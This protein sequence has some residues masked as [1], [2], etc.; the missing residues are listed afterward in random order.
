MWERILEAGLP[1]KGALER[2]FLF[3]M[4]S[5]VR[6]AAEVWFAAMYKCTLARVLVLHKMP[7]TICTVALIDNKIFPTFFQAHVPHQS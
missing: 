5:T 7:S 3:G 1:V 6:R 2:N 4:V